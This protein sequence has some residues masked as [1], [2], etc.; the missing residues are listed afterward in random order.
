MIF[1]R[2]HLLLAVS[3]SLAAVCLGLYLFLVRPVMVRRQKLIKETEDKVSQLRRYRK[4]TPSPEMIA[5]LK[6]EKE[7]LEN[8]YE[9]VMKTLNFAQ[10]VP[11]PGEIGKLHLYFEEQIERAEKELGHL[12]EISGINIPDRLGFKQERPQ[13]REE[14]SALLSQLASARELVSLV[15]EAGVSNLSILSPLPFS[16]E[17]AADRVSPGEKGLPPRRGI[18]PAAKDKFSLKELEFELGVRAEISALGN[19]LYRL[20]NHSCFFTVKDLEIKLVSSG[21]RETLR[22]R[23]EQGRRGRRRGELIEELPRERFEERERLPERVELEAK[24]LVATR[25]LPAN[26]E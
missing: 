21:R 26:K 16:G 25:L 8:Q 18:P 6:R 11:L 12:E 24:L 19:L 9:E 1:L 23:R 13:S 7:M 17:G 14:L 3:L 22:D 4:D 10:R 2:K 5:K 20:A 15:A